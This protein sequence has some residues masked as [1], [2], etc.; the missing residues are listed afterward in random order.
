MPSLFNR[1]AAA[2]FVPVMPIVAVLVM[3]AATPASA[4]PLVQ[5][6][7]SAT[8]AMTIIQ[9]ATA[10]CSRPG[11]LVT[12]TVAVVDRAGL[13]RM[14]MAGDTASPHNW[15]L[16]R[17]K[18]YTAR[19]YRRPSLEWAERTA[20]DSEVAGQRMLAD[21]VPLGGGMPIMIGDE[22]IGGVGVSGAMGGQPAD[23][24]CAQAAIAAIA[25]QLQ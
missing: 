4:Q 7:I 5:R 20:G 1:F 14:I 19:T 25:D 24:A 6:N 10:E 8:Q 23:Q 2:V 11:P 13:P 12:I 17:R 15:E 3:A 21:V 18:A 16:A 9:A 22:P